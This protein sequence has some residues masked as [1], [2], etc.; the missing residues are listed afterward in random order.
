MLV[1]V[2]WILR[3]HLLVCA[4]MLLSRSRFIPTGEVD[5]P[6]VV[7]ICDGPV[8]SCSVSPDPASCEAMQSELRAPEVASA[9]WKALRREGDYFTV[10]AELGK[11]SADETACHTALTAQECSMEPKCAAVKSCGVDCYNCYRLISEWPI[12]Q[13]SCRPASAIVPNEL[14][15]PPAAPLHEFVP[16]RLPGAP[17]DAKLVSDEEEEKK[18]AAAAKAAAEAAAA[19]SAP[20]SFVDADVSAEHAADH[21]NFDTSVLPEHED[22]LYRELHER[23]QAQARSGLPLYSHQYD[24]PAVAA[25]VEQDQSEYIRSALAAQEAL[26]AY[27]RA[28]RAVESVRAAREEVV[29]AFRLNERPAGARPAPEVVPGAPAALFEQLA[30]TNADVERELSR[31]VNANIDSL[32]DPF[33]AAAM[34]SDKHSRALA[35]GNPRGFSTADVPSLFLE[36]EAGVR[37]REIPGVNDDPMGALEKRVTE[38]EN[39]IKSLK[40]SDKTANILSAAIREPRCWDMWNELG[41]SRRAR[42]YM[43]YKKTTMAELN[44]DDLTQGLAWDAHSVCKCL[45]K[46]PM[47]PGETL[48]YA[49]SCKYTR[50]HEFLMKVAFPYIKH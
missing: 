8:F 5:N 43:S 20:T 2:V 35:A 9:L 22:M 44:P 11:C 18:K 12:F 29:G 23:T 28:R 21:S 17:A 13:E 14:E 36:M 1:R 49:H 45:G 25:L 50:S 27:R 30:G 32:P 41:Q 38:T 24:D 47:Q 6:E 34:A 7:R 15:P 39:S 16:L 46:C 19:K 26:A 48:Q 31:G 4:P 42:F 37:A 33:S 40:E 10:C 3:S